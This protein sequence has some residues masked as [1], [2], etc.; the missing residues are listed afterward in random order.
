MIHVLT[1]GCVILFQ[2][3]HFTRL[4]LSWRDLL[5]T[6]DLDWL[7]CGRDFGWSLRLLASCF[8]AGI[9]NQ[10]FKHAFQHSNWRRWIRMQRWL[11]N[12]RWNNRW[13]FSKIWFPGQSWPRIPFLMIILFSVPS[14]PQNQF[15]LNQI[16]C[17]YVHV[18]RC[19]SSRA[20]IR[21]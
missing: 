21:P 5:L 20:M 8:P 1:S 10:P 13:P 3:L 16:C 17:V 19:Y 2:V 12:I 14:W 9:V 15:L 6:C 11:W 4:M 7:T 18:L